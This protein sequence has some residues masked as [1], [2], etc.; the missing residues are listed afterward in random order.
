MK[1]SPLRLAALSHVASL[2]PGQCCNGWQPEALFVFQTPLPFSDICQGIISV[3]V[4][5]KHL[6][7]LWVISTMPYGRG[8]CDCGG[9]GVTRHAKTNSSGA[10]R[11][12]KFEGMLRCILLCM[13]DPL[14]RRWAGS[15]V[16]NSSP[17]SSYVFVIVMLTLSCKDPCVVAHTCER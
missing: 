8:V 12:E 11:E 16:L 13:S 14:S 6:R 17:A 5:T 1:Q 2:E 10:R 15:V 3:R 4:Y 9:D 7:V